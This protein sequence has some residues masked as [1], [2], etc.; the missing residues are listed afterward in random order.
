MASD[1]ED[2]V[3]MEGEEE[4]REENDDDMQEDEGGDGEP[5]VYLP[6]E[7]MDDDEE[8]VCDESAY[9]M[10]HQAQ[11][12][13][14]CL[15]FDIL[16]DDLG[17]DRETFPL[18]CYCAA[19]TQSERGHTNHVIVMKMGNLH[20]TQKEKEEEEDE[21]SDDEK[22]EEDGETP[23][24]E[25][26][27][28]KHSGNVNRIRSTNIGQKSI[29][30]SWSETG[31]VHIW[32]LSRPLNAVNDPGV[33]ATYTRNQESPPPL[34]TFTGHQ[35]EGFA[36]DWSPTITGRLL[37]GDCHKHIH[38]WTPQE[39]GTWLVDQ[40]PF[41]GHTASVEDV[42]WSPNEDNVFASCS[43]DRTIRVWDARAAPGKACMMTVTDAHDRDVNV[44]H[45]NQHEPFIVSGGDD[46]M[47]K[48]WDL[49]Q[50]Q[51]SKAA[52]TFKHHSAPITSVEWHPKDSS[53]FAA[54]G[55][56]DQVSL[57][58]LSVE[59]DKE[60]AGTTGGEPGE[61]GEPDV[62]PQLL[63]IHQGQTDIKEIHWHP[64]MPGVI[65]STAH[66]GFNIFRTI[67]V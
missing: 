14:P 16:R 59:R 15:S 39:D 54:S 62:P 45:W 28:M 27:L 58:D 9:I 41:I 30:A 11:T 36:L 52:A 25:T 23:E 44:I 26:V 37:S 57:W 38:L 17:D 12:G 31:K 33:M 61:P 60:V 18:T 13:A 66:S 21:E 55:S 53:V 63:F 24:L 42:Q 56:D 6:G 46:G 49:R 29:A 32:D 2:D 5:K 43:V 35:T 20:K 64:Q 34:F 22:D 7:E 4:V 67:S 3:N 48:V 50:I 10:Y 51:E 8:L 65:L 19:G 1:N 40:R 47:I